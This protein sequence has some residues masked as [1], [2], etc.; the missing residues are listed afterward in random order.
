MINNLK[1]RE[2]NSRDSK[3]DLIEKYQHL[4][5]KIADQFSEVAVSKD[6][7]EEVGYI[8]LLNAI[9]LY[10]KHLHKI[11]FKTYAQILITEEIHEYLI[12]RKR[13]VDRP[14]WLVDLNYK[15]DRF[16]IDYRKKYNCFPKISEISNYFNINTLGLQEILKSRESLRESHYLHGINNGFDDFQ[17]KIENIRSNSYQSFK[18]PIEDLIAL[19]KAFKKLKN[20]QESIVY[21]L[22]VMDLSQSRLAKM[23][24]ISPQQANQLKKEAFNQIK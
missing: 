23:L 21:Y 14:D 13:E 17:P 2:R 11:D 5:S 24:G 4:I 16:V 10:D 20:L 8:G 3:A 22:F 6:N 15:I 19:Q 18:L 1:N 12:N 7:L 9:N